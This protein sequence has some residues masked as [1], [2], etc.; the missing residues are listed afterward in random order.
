MSDDLEIRARELMSRLD[1]DA[2]AGG[3]NLNQDEEMVLELCTGLVTNIDRFGYMC[4]PCR[5]SDGDRQD[6]L[7]IICPCDYRDPDLAEFGA[8]Y[9]A[10]Y[11][12]DAIK[13]GEVKAEPIPD[14]RPEDP[15]DR[16]QAKAKQTGEGIQVWR[17]RV[18]GYLCGREEPPGKCP[19]CK[20]DKER[21]EPF[22]IK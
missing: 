3:Y 1:R 21:F 11:V 5:L 14:R 16:A 4:C 10:L 20:A 19:I 22:S 13:R 6:D 17:C 8:C 18:C 9:C 15:R 2:K 12:S 7:D